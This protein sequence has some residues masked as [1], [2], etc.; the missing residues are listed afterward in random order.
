[1]SNFIVPI[2]ILLIILVGIIEKKNVYS[3]FI[4]GVKE[5]IKVVFNI[6]PYIFAITIIS[7]LLKDTKILENVKLF[8]LD[9]NILPL[10]IMK[11]LSGGASTSMVV[12]IFKNI[13]PDSFT[14]LVASILMASTETTLYVISILGSKIKIK[15]LKIVVICGLIGDISAVISAILIASYIF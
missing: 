1:M 6:F 2:F 15:D 5:G 13:G 4:E 9:A 8:G 10:V 12:D 11:P 7:G 14:G 3:L